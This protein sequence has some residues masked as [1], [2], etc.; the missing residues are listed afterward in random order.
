MAGLQKND[1]RDSFRQLLEAGARV[2]SRI[3][4]L[5]QIVIAAVNGV[6]AGAG[7]N[8]ALAC[9]VRIAAES[10]TFSQAFVKIGLHPDWGGSWLLPRLIGPSR[11]LEIL[12]T[13]RMVEATEALAL[14]MVDRVTAGERLAVE[15]RDLATTIAAGPSGAISDIKRAVWASLSND[16]ES[17]LALES[18][19][20][21]RAFSSRDGREGVSAFLEKRKAAFD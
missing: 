13:G 11:A 5:P 2:V 19:N 1:D 18:E 3:R 16:L 20:Q 10:A 15:A 14:G 9:D 6:A 12:A 21:L 17:Q 4:T 8:L 7:C